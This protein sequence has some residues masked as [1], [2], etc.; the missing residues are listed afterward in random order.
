MALFRD[1]EFDSVT[2][3]VLADAHARIVDS[4]FSSEATRCLIENTKK[5]I[6]KTRQVLHTRFKGD[7]KRRRRA[8]KTNAPQAGG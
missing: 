6:E 8:R 7:P 3:Q 4:E 1:S 5:I 2:R